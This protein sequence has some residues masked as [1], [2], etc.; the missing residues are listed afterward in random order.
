MATEP[1]PEMLNIVAEMVD[2]AMNRKVT[3][4]SEANRSI[5]V[6]PLV[7]F[8]K[9][10]ECACGEVAPETIGEYSS[11]AAMVGA[12][13]RTAYESE[14]VRHF[15]FV[16]CAVDSFVRFYSVK[17]AEELVA[18]PP[19]AGE[20]SREYSQN[21]LTD[22]KEGFCILVFDRTGAYLDAFSEYKRDDN[23]LPVPTTTITVS[24]SV[25]A[26][27][28]K[29]VFTVMQ[30]FVTMCRLSAE[31]LPPDSERFVSGDDNE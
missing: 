8:V 22:V 11:P 13:L 5:D 24:D 12:L 1:S 18:N 30:E 3:I 17:D 15:D 27:N 7:M 2:Q 31:R 16:A 23:G 14:A 19:A 10:D 28:S 29:E 25:K 26:T 20:L 6:S 9:D 21:P 4:S